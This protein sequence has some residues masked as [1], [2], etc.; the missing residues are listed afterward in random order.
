MEGN[1]V[2]FE[3]LAKLKNLQTVTHKYVTSNSPGLDRGVIRNM[4]DVIAEIT[5]DSS[6]DDRQPQ[7][8]GT[9]LFLII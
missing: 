3:P 9:P 8:S 7:R 4:S 6:S 1:W 2:Y 5:M